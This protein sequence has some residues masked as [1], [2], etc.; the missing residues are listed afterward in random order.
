MLLMYN[1]GNFEYRQVGHINYLNYKRKAN[2]LLDVISVWANLPV[3][4]ITFIEVIN[5]FTEKFDIEIVYFESHEELL[6]TRFEFVNNYAR[7]VSPVFLERVS[8]FTIKEV[9]RDS[10][11]VFIQRFQN[12]QRLVFT[13]L[14]EFAHIQF[15]IKNERYSQLVS[16]VEIDGEYPPELLPF[17]DEAN[18][19]ASILYLN[20]L[21][22]FEYLQ[23]GNP[24][25]VIVSKHRMS[26]KALHCRLLN[27]LIYDLNVSPNYALHHYLL[28][29]RNE[30]F[31][32]KEINK[33]RF[34]LEYPK[35]IFTFQTN[36]RL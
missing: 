11:K 31:G 7:G 10:Y 27:Y 26:R 19:I 4:E 18:V 30:A 23:S 22:L 3:T 5:Y 12:F 13:I 21:K 28:P 17:E 33:I 2:S 24:F 29:Y 9:G 32:A 25:D 34:L 15:H 14:H 1:R 20:D 8:G 16:T 35:K 36:V 6:N